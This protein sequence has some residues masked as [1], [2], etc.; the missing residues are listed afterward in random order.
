M[1]YKEETRAIISAYR[2]TPYEHYV[3]VNIREILE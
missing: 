3:L 1:I 2:N